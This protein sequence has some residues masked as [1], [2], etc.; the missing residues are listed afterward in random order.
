MTNAALIKLFN[1]IFKKRCHAFCS[2]LIILLP[3]NKLMTARTLDKK[4]S[5]TKPPFKIGP[6]R[7]F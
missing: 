2:S 3:H 4:C 6:L 7:R 1:N 5:R